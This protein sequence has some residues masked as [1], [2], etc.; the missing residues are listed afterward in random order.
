MTPEEPPHYRAFMSYAHADRAAADWLFR[1][2]EGFRIGKDLKG[3]VTARGPIPD[4]LYP[5]FRDRNEFTP[6]EDLTGETLKALRQSAALI[7]LC[8][9]R[10]AASDNVRREIVMFRDLYGDARPIIPL[11]L[12]GEPGQTVDDW[13]PPP[14]TPDRLAAD[15]RVVGD[16]RDLA[17]AKVIAAL[18]GL[19]PE[20]VYRRVERERKRVFRRRVL[21]AV[22]VAA[23]VAG[24]GVAVWKWLGAEEVAATH[25]RSLAELHE[26]ALNYIRLTNPAA[27]VD[28]RS[29]EDLVG[30][31]RR[32][33]QEAATGDFRKAEV[34]NR[35]AAGDTVGALALQETVAKDA[36]VA[37][38][39]ARARVAEA[40][41]KAAEEYRTAA[42]LAGH[43]DPKRAREAYAAALRLD[44]DDVGSL[45]PFAELQ[46]HAGALV[47]AEAAYRRAIALGRPGQHDRDLYWSR[48]GLGD[49]LRA[50]GDLSGALHQYTIARN[51]AGRLLSANPN[52]R[53]WQRDFSASFNKLGDVL[54]AQGQLPDALAAYRDSLAATDRLA[55]SETS[56]SGLQRDLSLSFVNV[57]NL[58]VAQGNADEALVAYRHSLSIIERLATS[59]L[60]DAGYQRDLSVAFEKVGDV[61]MSQHQREDALVAYR[62]SLTISARLAQ[63]DPS[64]S[65]W[66]RDFSVALDKIGDVRVRL[67]QLAEALAAYRE[68]LTIVERL[69]KSDPSNRE[70][71]RDLAA[72]FSKIGNV[73]VLMG[74]PAQAMAV[75][76]DSLAITERLA[77]SDSSNAGWQRDMAVSLFKIGAVAFQSGDIGEARRLLTAGRAIVSALAARSP[78]WAVVRQD[79]EAFDHVLGMLPL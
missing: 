57:G 61:L 38:E 60:V 51:F 36:E 35:I 23:L 63:S 58:L 65:G 49:I 3:Q 4:R 27:A 10:S 62:E 44:P 75:Y 59:D 16:G 72:A 13:F 53:N 5:I 8:S 50:Q 68:S 37:V 2:L 25:G 31:L 55:R 69:A 64:N 19:P 15:W 67:G 76:R 26:L 43:G 56:N 1:G 7:V 11:I 77:H 14:L 33:D 20:Q 54:V 79:V 74:Q 48:L 6:G 41:K 34:L 21:V 52:D 24:G 30:T 22:V 66:Q 28:A 29:V 39:R 70:W 32:I 78:D 40:A 47:E 71:Q 9:P 42:R 73:L 18:L 46:F 17:L 12:G 45:G